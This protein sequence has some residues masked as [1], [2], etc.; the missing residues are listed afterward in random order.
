[1][2][3]DGI[4]YTDWSTDGIGYTDWSTDGIGYTDWSTGGIGYTDW[5]THGYYVNC[6][7]VAYSI[8]GLVY[9]VMRIRQ[10]LLYPHNIWLGEGA[11]IE[12]SFALDWMSTARLDLLK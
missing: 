5:S 6:Q 1:L 9:T 10:N 4:G 8:H 3:T 12:M 11:N 7:N 2:A